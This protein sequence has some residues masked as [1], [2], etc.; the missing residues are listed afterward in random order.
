MKNIFLIG[1]TVVAIGTAGYFWYSYMGTDTAT[2]AT[3]ARV[4]AQGQSSKEISELLSILKTLRSIKID[5][6]FTNDPVF[7]SLVDFSPP[8]AEP[9][10]KGRPN[11]FVSASAVN[12]FVS[13]SAGSATTTRR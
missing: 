9:M 12:A 5:S 6:A 10:S 1:I 8:M 3:V 13:F 7:Q 4:S 11:P 2:T